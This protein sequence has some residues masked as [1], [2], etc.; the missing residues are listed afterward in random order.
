MRNDVPQG[1]DYQEYRRSVARIGYQVAAV[2]AALV[3]IGGLL[4]I[5]YVLWQTR[6]AKLNE[7]HKPEDVRIFLDPVDLS[8]AGII[9]GLGAVVCAGLAAWLIARRAVRPLSDA[10]RMQRRFVADASHELRTPLAV[11]NARAQ[12]LAAMLPADDPRRPVADALREDTR[13]MAGIVDDML[14]SSTAA[15]RAT[16]APP[17]RASLA[18][19]TREVL[20]D[21]RLLAEARGVTVTGEPLDAEVALPGPS[22]RRCLL[23]LVDNAIDH[24]PEGGTV[25]V[26]AERRGRMVCVS[27]ADQGAGISGIETERVFDRFAHG[28][29]PAAADGTSRTRHGIGLALVQEIAGRHGGS[30]R[31]ARTGREGTVFELLLPLAPEGGG[32]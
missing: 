3:L 20:S 10:F 5:A 27:V 22:V 6:P 23:A 21:L 15:G 26:E 1:A 17:A 2:C 11:M 28:S 9:V 12:Q 31:V 16:A 7:P 18:A 30:V 29:A 8:V 4:A 24:S 13:I 14:E 25:T 19:S 32:A